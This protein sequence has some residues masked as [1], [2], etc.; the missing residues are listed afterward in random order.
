MF[1]GK[2]RH[3]I[4]RRNISE[5]TSINHVMKRR[6]IFKANYLSI[7][8]HTLISALF[9]ILKITD[10]KTYILCYQIG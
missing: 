5:A 2:N 4:L 6:L 9:S 7:K 10:H 1:G 3:E 8:L